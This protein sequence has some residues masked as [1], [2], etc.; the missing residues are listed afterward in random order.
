MT[1]S[2]TVVTTAG[3]VRG[4]VSGGIGRYLAIPYAAPA[5]GAARFASPTP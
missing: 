1:I 5:V 4:G 2:S 3:A